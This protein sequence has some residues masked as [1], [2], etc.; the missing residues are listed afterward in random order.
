MKDERI[1]KLA[2]KLIDYSVEL[3]KD[4]KVLIQLTSSDAIPLAKEIIRYVYFKEGVPLL[5]FQDEQLQKEILLGCSQEQ[6]KIMAES[7]LVKMKRVQAHIYI[8][9][10][11][12]I[13]E[14]SGVSEEKLKDYS[15]YFY[16]PVHTEYRL[17]KLKWCELRYPNASMAQLANMSTDDFEEFF[18]QVCN[19]DYM[20]MSKCMDILMDVMRSTDQ[21]RIIGKNTN[22]SFSIKGI[23]ICKC[24]GKWNLPDGEVASAPIKTSVNG[25]ITYNVPSVYDGFEYNN[26]YI[27]FKEGKVIK[28]ISNNTER[29]NKILDTDEGSRYLGEFA[30][31]VNPYIEKP[32]KDIIFDEKICGSIHLALGSCYDHIYNGNSSS[33]HWDLIQIQTPEYG[34]GEIWFDDKLIRKDGLF[35]LKELECLNPENLK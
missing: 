24:D 30:F 16:G 9:A 20:K 28:A 26:V 31:G 1:S 10:L 33:I 17:K 35:V 21:V 3:K 11:E 13:N 12:N 8:E 2:K 18:F 23:P 5:S 6:L 25:Y 15:N 7:E 14:R 27:E 22:L 19:M 32:I 29:L 4:E 34:G